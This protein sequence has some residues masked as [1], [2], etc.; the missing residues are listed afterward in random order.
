MAQHSRLDA[1]ATLILVISAIAVTALTVR[2]ELFPV[3]PV[4]ELTPVRVEDWTSY[5]TPH[6]RIGTPT[7]AVTLVVFSDF[8]CPF[9]AQLASTVDTVLNRYAGQVALD[10]R[11][12]P[13]TSIHR[14]AKAAAIAAECARP[15]GRFKEL[16]DVLFADIGRL[17]GTSW[18][19]IASAAGVADTAAFIACMSGPAPAE[20]LAMD[21]LAAV[22][23][24][25]RG[26]PTL[27]VNEWR[28]GGA[29]T[30]QTLDSLVRSEL[31]R[32]SR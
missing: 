24:G 16:H 13:I 29:P 25:V 15:A 2:R 30:L 8:E 11:H 18:S 3:T 7:P 4:S 1:L 31:A 20:K 9:C 27:L 6:T 12:F 23:L 32:S 21:S 26:T 19:A 17:G 14:N 10:F 28:I 5:Q 22:R